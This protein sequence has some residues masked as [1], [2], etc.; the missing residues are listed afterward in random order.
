M[1]SIIK[2]NNESKR[3]RTGLLKSIKG[4]QVSKRPPAQDYLYSLLDA[5]LHEA[6]PRALSIPY[7]PQPQDTHVIVSSRSSN[8][9]TSRFGVTRPSRTL[10]S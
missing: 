1:F 10:A 9:N 3:V 2:K 4:S 5:Y 6:E 7:P 8:P